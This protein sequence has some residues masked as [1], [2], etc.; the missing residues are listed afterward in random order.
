M[1]MGEN[2]DRQEMERQNMQFYLST[3]TGYYM[4]HMYM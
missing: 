4:Y 3:V 1:A 2:V